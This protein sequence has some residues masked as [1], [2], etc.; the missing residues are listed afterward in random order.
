MG[1]REGVR[2]AGERVGKGGHRGRGLEGRGEAEMGEGGA[3]GRDGGSMGKGAVRRP[4][5]NKA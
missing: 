2:Q 4:M 3:Y 1:K 5:G